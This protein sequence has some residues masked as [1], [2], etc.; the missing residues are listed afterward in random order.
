MFLLLTRYSV[1]KGS[2]GLNSFRRPKRQR[3]KQIFI[4][5]S[6]IKVIA[7]KHACRST[8][9]DAIKSAATGKV[10]DVNVNENIKDK[11]DL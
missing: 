3:S 11:T 8:L 2:E 10:K 7:N 1:R 9:A 5:P 6:I 4:H